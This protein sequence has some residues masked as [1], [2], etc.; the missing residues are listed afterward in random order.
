MLADILALTK[1]LIKIRSTHSRPD[2]IQRCADCIADFLRGFG[3]QYERFT[4]AGIP[5]I[6]V[7]P[8]DKKVSVLLMTHF[9]VVD[10][11][12]SH[13]EPYEKDGRLYGRGSIDDKYAV[14]LSLVLL[15]ERLLRLKQSDR[16]QNDLTF[17]L[18][19]TGDEEIG[20]YNGAKKQ[21]ADIRADFCIALDGGNPKTIITAEKGILRLKLMSHGQAA[22]GARPWLGENAIEKLMADY[23]RL[24]PFFGGTRSDH[25]HRTMS[26][27][28]IKA[29]MAGNQVPDCAEGILDIRY[30]EHDDIEALLQAMQ[31][32]IAGELVVEA[33]EPL[34]KGGLSPYVKLLR[35]IDE[36]ISFNREH[37][38]SDARH[39]SS[40]GIDGVVWGAD[41]EMSQHGSDEHVIIESIASLYKYLNKFLDLANEI[42]PSY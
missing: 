23:R 39:L 18:L 14:A 4:H 24:T 37:G 10:A 12:D 19:L 40:F 33:Q 26:F 9:D 34:F 38:A 6:R 31:S 16:S 17:G 15:K 22:H 2:E 21:L 13:F 29:G 30:T 36:D 7:L 8:A 20:G 1:T 42:N 32:S 27:T 5:S 3:I 35:Q 41:G 25:W 11:D 28:M